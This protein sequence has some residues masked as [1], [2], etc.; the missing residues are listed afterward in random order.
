MPTWTSQST[1]L[2]ACLSA[3]TQ[4]IVQDLYELMV[5]AAAYD[6]VGPAVRSKDILQDTVSVLPPGEISL[7]V[8]TSL[9][10]LATASTPP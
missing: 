3:Q 7:H 5:Q 6:N 4:D 9:S 1:K 10:I 2:I 8:L